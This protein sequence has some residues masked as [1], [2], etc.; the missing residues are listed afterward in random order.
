MSVAA[1]LELVPVSRG[2]LALTA[3]LDA[4]V[5]ITGLLPYYIWLVYVHS[6]AIRVYVSMCECNNILVAIDFI[7]LLLLILLI[8]LS[9]ITK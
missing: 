6:G 4:H 8:L 7:T 5:H 9:K 3:I 1:E 2:I